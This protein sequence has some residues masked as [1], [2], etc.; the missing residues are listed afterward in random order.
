MIIPAFIFDP[1]ILVGRIGRSALSI[2][3]LL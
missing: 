2:D 3:R 1:H